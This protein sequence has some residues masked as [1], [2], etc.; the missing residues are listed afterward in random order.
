MR[1]LGESMWYTLYRYRD[2]E[3]MVN[4]LLSYMF[5][6]Y[7]K[8]IDELRLIYPETNLFSTLALSDGNFIHDTHGT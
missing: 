7:E 8:R 5:I 3:N 1:E 6:M 2:G 4:T